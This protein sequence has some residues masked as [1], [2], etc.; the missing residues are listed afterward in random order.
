MLYI[1]RREVTMIRWTVSIAVENVSSKQQ[2]TD[3][4]RNWLLVESVR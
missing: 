3:V 2:L 4:D 1:V